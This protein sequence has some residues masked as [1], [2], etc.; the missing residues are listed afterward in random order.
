MSLVYSTV[1]VCCVH[2]FKTLGL[3]S[4]RVFAIMSVPTDLTIMG[5]NLAKITILSYSGVPADCHGLTRDNCK[6]LRLAWHH[7]PLPTL[8]ATYDFSVRS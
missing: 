3:R 8:F 6:S 7:H 5:I 1:V 2:V 4:W